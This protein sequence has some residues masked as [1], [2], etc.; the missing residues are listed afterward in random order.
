MQVIRPKVEID[1]SVNAFEQAVGELRAK[2]PALVMLYCAANSTCL[3]QTIRDK[4]KCPTILV[5]D[6]L[7]KNKFVWAV[8]YND[9]M[10]CSL[11]TA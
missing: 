9:S 10:Y 1:L 6:E 3:A 4:Y 2:S 8:E 5:P 11:P 7:L